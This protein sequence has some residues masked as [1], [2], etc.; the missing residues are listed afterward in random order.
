MS[1]IDIV[2][3]VG[4]L[5]YLETWLPIYRGQE[6]TVRDRLKVSQSSPPRLLSIRTLFDWFY[7]RVHLT[8]YSPD[9]K[10]FILDI[11]RVNPRQLAPTVGKKGKCRAV[12]LP[13]HASQ[14]VGH[15]AEVLLPVETDALDRPRLRK[16]RFDPGLHYPH[17]QTYGMRS[18]RVKVSPFCRENPASLSATRL[19]RTVASHGS[20]RWDMRWSLRWWRF[21]WERS[22]GQ[23]FFRCFLI[24]RLSL[25]KY[26]SLMLLPSAGSFTGWRCAID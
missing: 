3:C 11:C 16:R 20:V 7:L 8:P 2:I 23:E 22:I 14:T 1:Y 13:L 26:G 12:P 5:P 19:K 24:V 17:P 6:R 21:V 15:S 9:P 10:S 4:S 18:I 25:C